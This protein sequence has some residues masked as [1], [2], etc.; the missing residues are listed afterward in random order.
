V[1]VCVCVG[2]GGGEYLGKIILFLIWIRFINQ[3]PLTIFPSVSMYGPILGSKNI[4]VVA[5]LL[6]NV[7]KS[8]CLSLF[9][10]SVWVSLGTTHI[11]QVS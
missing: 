2:G 5:L 8:V 11:P 7:N 6:C 1:C 10:G 9:I 3:F 4:S